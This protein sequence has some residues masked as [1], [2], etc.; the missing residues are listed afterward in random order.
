MTITV[1]FTELLQLVLQLFLLTLTIVCEKRAHAQET[2]TNIKKTEAQ[3]IELQEHARK[4]DEELQCLN[5]R[6]DSV[7]QIL[8]A[9]TTKI[10]GLKLN[11]VMPS[12]SMGPK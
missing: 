2:G 12:F 4:T 7:M 5:S 3:V 6:L 11:F 9:L 1:P 8:A 10:D